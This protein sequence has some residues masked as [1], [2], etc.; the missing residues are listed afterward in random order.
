MKTAWLCRTSQQQTLKGCCVIDLELGCRGTEMDTAGPCPHSAHVAGG[1]GV[2]RTGLGPGVWV[3]ATSEVARK[4]RGRQ[5]ARRLPRAAARLALE[6][7]MATPQAERP[8]EWA[9]RACVVRSR[10]T[11]RTRSP[12]TR[13]PVRS[14]GASRAR[15]RVWISFWR[16]RKEL[17]G[18]KK[19]ATRAGWGELRSVW[20]G[21]HK[22]EVVAGR[23]GW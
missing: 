18:L 13:E 9:F 8:G 14:R 20:R 1:R 22:E 7:R 3:R 16:T 10:A 11:Q 6:G 21:N 12:G 19:G 15:L 23:T 2:P 5:G 4:S 17:E